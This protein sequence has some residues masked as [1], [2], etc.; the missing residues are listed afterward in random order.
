MDEYGICNGWLTNVHEK[1]PIHTRMKSIFSILIFLP[2]ATLAQKIRLNEFDKFIKQHRIES[3]PLS[4]FSASH[5]KMSVCLSAV[6]PKLYIQLVGAG[7]GA[8]RIDAEDRVIFLMDNDSTITVKSKG[9]QGFDIGVTTSTYKHHYI[10]SFSD[11]EKLSQYNLLA[12][13]KYHSEDY[14]D[15]SVSKEVSSQFK[16]LCALF[17]EELGKS[18][19]IQVVKAPTPDT[20]MAA[21]S[22]EAALAAEKHRADSLAKEIAA[23]QKAIAPAFPGGEEVW[24]S[25]LRRNLNPPA[26]LKPGESKVVVVQFLVT[27]DGSVNDIKIIQTAGPSYDKEVLRVLKR[28]PKWKSAIENGRPVDAIVTQS[29]TFFHK[30]PVGVL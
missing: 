24:T 21:D 26:E 13:R 23:K 22:K 2:F 27:A 19:L 14:D 7:L 1:K 20:V 18:S 5:M 3:F 6:G 9:Y 25:F 30:E 28:M 4:L 11:L 12:L 29:V 10:L 17:I 8:N 15:V 16:A